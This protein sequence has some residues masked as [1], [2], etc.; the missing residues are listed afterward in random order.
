MTGRL[1]I[2]CVLVLLAN[3]ARPAVGQQR[4]VDIAADSSSIRVLGGRQVVELFDVELEQD[5]IRL[6]ARHG[7]DYGNGEYLFSRNV[8]II[9]EADTLTADQVR[10]NRVSKTGRA[11]GRVR[12]GDGEVVVTAPEGDFDLDANRA[13]FRAGVRMVDSVTVLTSQIGSYWTKEKRA[14]FF[15]EVRLDSDDTDVLADSLTYFRQGQRSDARGNVLVVWRKEGEQTFILGDRAVNDDSL[16]TGAAFGNV[17]IGRVSTDSTTA[18]ADT[19]LIRA[20]RVSSLRTDDVDQTMASGGVIVSDADLS[21]L[22]DSVFQETGRATNRTRSLLF[23][24]PII[25]VDESQVNGDSVRIAGSGG[26]IDSLL[27]DGVAYVAQRDTL[28]DKIQ[29][30]K[31]RGLIG[32]FEND[33]LRVMEVSPNAEAVYFNRDDED[34]IA[35]AL[36]VTADRIRFLFARG[37]ISDLRVYQD[38]DGTY[39]PIELIPEDLRL[40]GVVWRPQDKPD[41]EPLLRRLREALVRFRDR[42]DDRRQ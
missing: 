3:T 28:I 6:R 36:R 29:Q 41:T 34:Q 19:L 42:E 21:A 14:E 22:A 10:Y 2:L 26:R 8:R 39:F 18:K 24:D 13:D 16:G 32:L 20:D 37:E 1:S 23:G 15:G 25:W 27:V 4:R 17:L 33:S 30:L 9:D 40:D 5:T 31:G 11:N 38:V 35:G 12:L 7:I